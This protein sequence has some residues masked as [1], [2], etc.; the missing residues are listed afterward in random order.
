[1][2]LPLR[3]A[4]LSAAVLSLASGAGAQILSGLGATHIYGPLAGQVEARPSDAE[5]MAAWPAAAKAKNQSGSAVMHCLADLAGELSGCQVMLERAG[6]AGFGP[7]LLSLAP[8]YRLTHAAE[9]K[10]PDKTPVV[11]SATWPAPETPVDWQVQPKPG[12]FMTTATPSAWRAGGKGLVVM[13]CLSAQMGALHDCEVVYQDPP[14]LGF[15][16]MALRFQG[17]LQLKPATVGGKGVASG[18]DIVWDFQRAGPR[19]TY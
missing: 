16:A 3:S 7:A 14:G 1:M 5:V 10:R 2:H 18:V 8:A 19:D 12:D 17:Y 13:N 6:R 11:I 4:L 15:G 9:G